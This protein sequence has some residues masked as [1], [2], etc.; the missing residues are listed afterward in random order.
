MPE[1]S[2]VPRKTKGQ[3]EKL[4]LI[5]RDGKWYVY[6]ECEVLKKLKLIECDKDCKSCWCG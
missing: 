4:E 5:K 2:I 3:K 1:F 6:G